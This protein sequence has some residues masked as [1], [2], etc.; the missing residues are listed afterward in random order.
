[1]LFGSKPKP[2]IDSLR[3]DVADWKYHGEREPGRTRVWEAPQRDAISLH[4]FPIPPDLPTVSTTDQL[5]Q[6]YLAQIGTSKTRVVECTVQLFAN[7][8]TIRLILK[9]PQTPHGFLYQAS[10]TIPFRDF[11]YVIKVQCAEVGMTGMREA[12]LTQKRLAA[13][14]KPNTTGTGPFFPGWNPDSPEFDAQFPAHPISRLRALLT[15]IAASATLDKSIRRLPAF[16]LPPA[17]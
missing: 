5:Q 7:L 2:T 15:R 13:G 6:F 1:M 11:S 16:P 3:F 8:P 4:F 17:I 10:L 14:E 9:V 12:V